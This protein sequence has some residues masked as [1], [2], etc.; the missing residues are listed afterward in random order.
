MFWM[1]VQVLVATKQPVASLHTPSNRRCKYLADAAVI[2]FQ[3]RLYVQINNM[4]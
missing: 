3:E 2:G 4:K 1:E